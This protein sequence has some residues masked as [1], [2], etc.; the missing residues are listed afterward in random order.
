M[1][2]EWREAHTKLTNKGIVD[3]END[4]QRILWI[5]S[6]IMIVVVGVIITS[7]IAMRRVL[8]KPLDEVISHIR[9]IAA[10]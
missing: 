9:A 2:R 7:W 1:Y 3:N 6:A 10:A 8:L 5:L 4:Y